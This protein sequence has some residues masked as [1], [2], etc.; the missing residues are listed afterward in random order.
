MDAIN[1][2]TY[3]KRLIT[4]TLALLLVGQLAFSTGTRCLTRSW[5]IGIASQGAAGSC[6]PWSVF[7]VHHVVP[8]HLVPGTLI[9]F[10]PP[11]A[12]R[13]LVGALPVVKMIAAGP[14]ELVDERDG[15]IWIDGHYWGRTWLDDY[16]RSAGIKPPATEHFVVPPKTFLV[17]GTSADSYDGRYWGVVPLSSIDGTAGPL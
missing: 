15:A 7:V 10:E 3:R 5:T 11:P 16:L 13:Q 1:P 4:G 8:A 14:G 17:L 6:L 9:E 12:M 2:E